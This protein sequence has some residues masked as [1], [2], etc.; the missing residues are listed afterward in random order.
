MIEMTR[1]PEEMEAEARSVGLS[2][3][4]VCRRAGLHRSLFTKWKAGQKGIT[5]ESYNSLAA[6]IMAAKADTEAAD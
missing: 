3:N 4:E 6:V 5:A 1:P 2:M